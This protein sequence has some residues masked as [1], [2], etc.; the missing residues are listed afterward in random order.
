[1]KG[2]ELNMPTEGE[3]SVAAQ[4][5][6]EAEALLVAAFMDGFHF[7]SPSQE[8]PPPTDMNNFG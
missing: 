4:S 6:K 5:R 8:L 7:H 2:R 3:S 1:M